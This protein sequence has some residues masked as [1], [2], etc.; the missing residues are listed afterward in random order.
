MYCMKAKVQSEF[1]MT[2]LLKT[3]NIIFLGNFRQVAV[4]R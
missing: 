2:K 1:N 3:K 4:K